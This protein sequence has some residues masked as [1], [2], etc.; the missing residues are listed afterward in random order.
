MRRAAAAALM[1]VFWVL[2]APVVLA[3]DEV[4]GTSPSNG[5]Q[6]TAAPDEVRIRFS[7]EARPRSGKA[8]IT[9]P[10][11]RS[12]ASG[13]A[14]VRGTVL[15]IPMRATKAAGRYSVEF[16]TL[17][18]DGHPVTGSLT[19]EVVKPKTSTAP[20][21]SAAAPL[22][23]ADDAEPSPWWPW[24]AGAGV[25]ALGVAAIALVRRASRTDED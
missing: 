8:S 3:H 17:A 4:I 12:V 20:A 19:F 23:A 22:P 5:E 2:A 7:A 24:V 6:L 25:A 15:V 18:S 21:P 1:L 13:P 10:D 11:G 9:G 14:R 16:R